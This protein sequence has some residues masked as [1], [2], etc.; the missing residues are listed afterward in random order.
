[1][2]KLVTTLPLDL[3]VLI[4]EPVTVRLHFAQTVSGLTVLKLLP[5]DL[6]LET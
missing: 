1:M 5:L 6:K 3:K 4:L 2:L